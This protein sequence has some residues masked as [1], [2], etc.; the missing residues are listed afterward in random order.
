MTAA[1]KTDDT[2]A[3]LGRHE[4][5]KILS[6]AIIVNK[7]GDG[8]SDAVDIE[9][10]D[11]EVDGQYNLSVKIRH[12]KTRFD[13]VYTKPDKDSDDPPLLKGVD[14][15]DIFDAITVVFD[16]R[17]DTDKSLADMRQ[18]IAAEAKRKKDAASGQF[19]LPDPAPG[20]TAD[21]TGDEPGEGEGSEE[22]GLKAR[23]DEIRH[24]VPDDEGA[25]VAG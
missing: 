20:E 3:P 17:E 6:R 4:G 19:T 10:H 5:L 14:Q 2:D 22:A 21:A 18:R 12:R 11:V 25:S 7:T 9:P 15:V 13:N 16:D 8:L 24:G 1:R 23:V